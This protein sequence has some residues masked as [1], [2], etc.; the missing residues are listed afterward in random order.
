MYLY[1]I[2]K[3]TTREKEHGD[4]VI[5]QELYYSLQKEGFKVFFAKI[6]LENKIGESYEPYIYAALNSSKVMLVIGSKKEYFEAPWVKNEWSRFQALI[7]NGDEK[8]II[9]CYK[10]M[11]P[12]DLPEEFAY[13]QAQDMSKIGFEQD[14]IYGIKKLVKKE[15]KKKQNKIPIIVISIITIILITVVG[16]LMTNSQKTNE[17]NET[18]KQIVRQDV[19][20][21]SGYTFNV[22]T[23][24]L[25][26]KIM[27]IVKDANLQEKTILDPETGEPIIDE[28]T[29]EEF[30][31]G[32]KEK[33]LYPYESSIECVAIGW[34]TNVND[35]P[36]GSTDIEWSAEDYEDQET[37]VTG[38]RIYSSNG[39]VTGLA[40]V[41]PRYG[42]GDVES[43]TIPL[44][45]YNEAKKILG[46][47]ESN[48]KELVDSG[49]ISE[50]TYDRSNYE[51]ITDG[52]FFA[53]MIMEL[54]I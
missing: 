36:E 10:E 15:S 40:C 23:E 11:D 49:I 2:K 44:N 16:I 14:L 4:S 9:P 37:D 43:I 19:L 21:S 31:Y 22:K 46:G 20:S 34:F 48:W 29:G 41:A 30:K 35:L 45:L 18:A 3:Q 17:G 26:N 6:T 13:L 52:S 50:K 28:T 32:I 33:K 1:A 12:Y 27:K 54:S 8:T 42:S 39:Y 7:K 51:E 53:G 47:E 25:K 5:A 24:D 38:I